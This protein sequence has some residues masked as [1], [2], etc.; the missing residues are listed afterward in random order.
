SVELAKTKFYP[1]IGVGV[2]WTQVGS[3]QS[4]GVS[5][6]GKD[7][8][9]LMFSINIP[10]WRDSYKAGERQAQARLR[11]ARFEKVE[12]ENQIIATVINVL[13][14]ID[15]SRR[16]TTLFGDTLLPKTETLVQASE[17]AY[18]SGS[19]DFLSLIDA[20]RM[21]LGYRLDHE[22]V[23]INY[24]QNLAELE[25]LIGKELTPMPAEKQEALEIMP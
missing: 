17:T 24:Q 23:M 1:D 25:M 13:Y 10:L 18:K 7:A 5:D 6:S 19:E 9:A 14:E 11:K 22:R 4:P 3:A 12:K 21:L 16:K 15:D 8:V 2:D 20:Q